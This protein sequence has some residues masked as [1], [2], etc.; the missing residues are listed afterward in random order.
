MMAFSTLEALNTL[1]TSI[2]DWNARLDELNSQIALRQIELARLTENERP[3]TR[4]LKNKSSTESLRPKDGPDDLLHTE[5]QQNKDNTVLDPL[6][7]PTSQDRV[8]RPS[9]AAAVRAATSTPSPSDANSPSHGALPRKPS[10]NTPAAQRRT[11]PAVLRKRKTE[12]VGSGE[13]IVPKYRTRSMIIVY[14]DSAVQTAFEELVKFVSGSRNSMRKGKMAAKMAEMRRAAQLEIGDDDDD[15]AQDD[16][17]SGAV[18]NGHN[19][20]VAQKDSGVRQQG[21]SLAVGP[22]P[23]CGPDMELPKLKFVSTRQMGPSRA[24]PKPDSYGGTLGLLGGYRRAGGDI[25]ESLDKGLDWVQ[26]QCEHAAHQFLREGECSS[27]IT[28]IKRKLDGVKE[29]AEK[30]IEKLKKDEAESPRSR[31]SLAGKSL[32]MKAPIVRKP[33]APTTSIMEVDHL[34]VDEGVDDLELP[35]KLLFRRSKDTGT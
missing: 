22:E 16:F 26:V 7:A 31:S 30:E 10:Q 12:S 28:S 18:N 32:Q 34:E 6:D 20:L 35:P 13:S 17:G 9:S 25:F 29:A 2:P 21:D 15:D 24:T 11:G 4:S 23:D 14:Y 8:P 5:E 19:L 33:P 27:E 3:P 1:C